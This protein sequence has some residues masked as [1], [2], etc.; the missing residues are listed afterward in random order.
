MK[1]VKDHFFML[2]LLAMVIGFSAFKYTNQAELNS[3][4]WYVVEPH[5][6]NPD[7][8]LVIHDELAGDADTEDCSS[9]NL[10][11]R[12]SVGLNQEISTDMTISA[13]NADPNVNKTGDR[14]SKP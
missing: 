14:F 6:T 9:A 8:D 12:C 13:I 3:P 5:P 7:L 1:T 4:Y 11:Q 10:G 2:A